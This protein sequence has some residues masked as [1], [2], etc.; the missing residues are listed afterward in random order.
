MILLKLISSRLKLVEELKSG[1]DP[2]RELKERSRVWR[3]PRDKTDG[4]MEPENEL[5]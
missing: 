1:R 2:E 5:E 4:G 3:E